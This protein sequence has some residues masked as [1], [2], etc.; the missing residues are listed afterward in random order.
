[1]RQYIDIIDKNLYENINNPYISA[2]KSGQD[3]VWIDMMVV[4]PQQR[5]TGIGRG[6]YKNWESNLPKSVKLVKLMAA[7]PSAIRVE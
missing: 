5:G 4:P 1:M 7:D 3:V 6:F 2:R